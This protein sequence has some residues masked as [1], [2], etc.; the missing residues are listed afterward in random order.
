VRPDTIELRG[1]PVQLGNEVAEHI[2]EWMRE[3]RLIALSRE[4]GTARLDVPDRLLEMVDALTR[5]YAAELD[6]PEQR[7]LAAAARGDRTVDLVY[8]VRPETEQVVTAWQTMLGEVDE[9]CRKEDLLTLQR[10]PEQVALQDWILDEFLRQIA[11]ESPRP[12]Q[13]AQL[14]AG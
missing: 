13:D 11:G 10:P 6:E 5:Q 3:F 12:W 7:R 9:Y 14:A 2:E 1:Y 8:P 4:A